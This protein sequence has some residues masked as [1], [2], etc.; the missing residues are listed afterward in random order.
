[1]PS[2]A[3]RGC[4]VLG[5]IALFAFHTVFEFAIFL[6]RFRIFCFCR[7]LF[8]CT[9]CFW[10][11]FMFVYRFRFIFVP[12]SVRLWVKSETQFEFV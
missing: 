2:R 12:A 10:Y 1:M 5:F 11:G 3:Y 8:V 9:V 4:H 6:Y 7:F